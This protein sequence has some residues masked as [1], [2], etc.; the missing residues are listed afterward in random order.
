[1]LSMF[2]SVASDW[3]T[4]VPVANKGTL[5]VISITTRNLGWDGQRLEEG[6]LLGAQRGRL[7][8]DGDVKGRDGAG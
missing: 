2:N 8:R 3:P 7:G 1:M 6:S 5:A 4:L